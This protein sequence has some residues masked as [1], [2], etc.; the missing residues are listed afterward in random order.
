MT[1]GQVWMP[2]WFA[3]SWDTQALVSTVI[4]IIALPEQVVVI[5]K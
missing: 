4:F 1:C 5:M 2:E 3:D